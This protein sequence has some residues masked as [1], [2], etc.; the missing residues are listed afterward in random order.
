MAIGLDTGFFLMVLK[1]QEEAL[2]VWQSLMD[3][4]ESVTSCLTLFELRRLSLS[5][6]I[7]PEAADT[8]I[9]AIMAISKVSWLEAAELLERGA[10]LSHGLGIPAMDALILTG[11][12]ASGA[13]VILTTDRHLDAFRKKGIQVRLLR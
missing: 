4:E 8:M 11:L 1:G 12:L 9:E 13:E 7:Q 2:R 3:G 5:G 6:R 10:Q